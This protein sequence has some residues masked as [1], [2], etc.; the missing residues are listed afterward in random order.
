MPHLREH[1]KGATPKH[2]LGVLELTFILYQL[3]HGLFQT[4]GRVLFFLGARQG[5]YS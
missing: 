1:N 3:R 4:K 5:S 2:R